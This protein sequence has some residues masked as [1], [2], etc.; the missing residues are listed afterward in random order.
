MMTAMLPTGQMP[1]EVS[2]A[3]ER[4]ERLLWVG[5]PQWRFRLRS[6][7]IFP[8]SVQPVPGRVRCG[9]DACA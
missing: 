2:Q 8:Y 3:L 7:D 4:G 9:G 1:D 5:A 6:A